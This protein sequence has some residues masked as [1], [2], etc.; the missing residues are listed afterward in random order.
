MEARLLEDGT[1]IEPNEDVGRG[2]ARLRVIEPPGAEVASVATSDGSRAVVERDEAGDERLAVRDGRGVL[3]FEYSPGA[4][5]CVVHAPTRDLVLRADEGSIDLVAAQG[6]R[7]RG[8][9]LVTVETETLRTKASRAE[10]ELDEAMVT[11]GVLTSS[12]RRVRQTVDILETSAGRIVERAR[13]TYRE[14]EGLAQ[15]RAERIRHVAERTVHVLAT[16]TLF[17]ARED[18]KLKGEKIHLG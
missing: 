12:F 1:K 9:E 15:V 11:A 7:L 16:H 13:E 2:Q 6:I 10:V 14:V 4:S 17:K 5:R 18:L 3:L 8:E